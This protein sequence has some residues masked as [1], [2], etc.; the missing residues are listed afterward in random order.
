MLCSAPLQ[1][2]L[3]RVP[4]VDPWFCRD[5]AKP[6]KVRCFRK[7]REL[8]FDTVPGHG[9]A[10][11]DEPA[12]SNWE[13]ASCALPTLA[14]RESRLLQLCEDSVEKKS[15]L[16]ASYGLPGHGVFSSGVCGQGGLT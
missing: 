12:V 16:L 5:C 7:E 2:P 10:S 14:L 3:E 11:F 15:Q 13:L 1:P 8:S 4:E 6:I 9:L